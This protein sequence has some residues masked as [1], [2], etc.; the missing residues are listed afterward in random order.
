M[1]FVMS[2]HVL[3]TIRNYWSIDEDMGV[4]F[5]ANVI[6]RTR[7]EQSCQN[8]H[9]CYNDGQSQVSNRAYKIRPV[10]QHFNL[11]FQKAMNNSK[12]QSIDE[13]MI[14]FIRHNIMEQYITNKPIEWG[15]KM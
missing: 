9:Y 14:K 4:P 8:L 1:N 10:M 3:P 7:L 11:Y 12:R 6:P 5:T 2:Y 15:L 13:H